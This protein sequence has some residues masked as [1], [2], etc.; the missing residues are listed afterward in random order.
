MDRGWSIRMCRR[1]RGIWIACCVLGGAAVW[2]G[3]GRMSLPGLTLY[4]MFSGCL[5]TACVMDLKEQTIYR[6]VW[7]AAA[8][9]VLFFLRFQPAEGGAGIWSV[10]IFILM[11]EVFF[12]RL[13]GRG[14]CHGFCVCAMAAYGLGGIFADYVK[15]MAVVFT[16]LTGVQLI[17]RNVTVT[18]KLKR[19]V[20]LMPYMTVGFWLWVDFVH[21]K[22]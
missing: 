19:P 3:P 15:H 7:P 10:V 20:P 5:I 6:Y 18:G 9:P 12:G 4:S 16:L 1:E 22:W 14:D 13:Y 2:L 17:R 11:Q 8:L 21:G